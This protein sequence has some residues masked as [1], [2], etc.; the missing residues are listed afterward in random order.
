M[1]QQ[2]FNKLVELIEIT[3]S[4]LAE[5]IEKSGPEKTDPD[6]MLKFA[7]KTI[8]DWCTR[9]IERRLQEQRSKQSE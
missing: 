4:L 2:Q 7:D 1:D 6:E 5:L 8:K 3:N 9:D